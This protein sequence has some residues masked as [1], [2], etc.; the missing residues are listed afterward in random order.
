M[1]E[2]YGNVNRARQPP[3]DVVV[4]QYEILECTDVLTRVV[5]PADHDVLTG[6]GAS[7]EEAFG[8]APGFPGSSPCNGVRRRWRGRRPAPAR[9]AHKDRSS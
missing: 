2:D 9:L 4:A 5:S 1:E 6:A 7:T 3:Q 8:S